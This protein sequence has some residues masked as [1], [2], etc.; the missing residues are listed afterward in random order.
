MPKVDIEDVSLSK[1]TECL[2]LY[3]SK[4]SNEKLE[5]YVLR[6][7]SRSWNIERA[8]LVRNDFTQSIDDHWSKK[9]LIWN[10]LADS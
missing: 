7:D 5:G 10:K 6:N 3:P 8:K 2:E 9:R 4:Y 1:L